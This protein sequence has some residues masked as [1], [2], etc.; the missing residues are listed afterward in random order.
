MAR[1]LLPLLA[2]A[3]SLAVAGA[4]T[5]DSIGKKKQRIDQQLSQVQLQLA[6]S[7]QVEERL[8]HQV[9]TLTTSIHRIELRVGGVSQR[10]SALNRDIALHRERLAKL[11]DL[12]HVQT[13]RYRTL[14][15]QYRLAV[16]RFDERLLR[17]YEEPSPNAVDV[18]LAS[19]SLHDALDAMNYLGAVAAQDKRIATQVRTAS[20][21]AAVAR[22]HTLSVRKTVEA[23]T[24]VIRG[25]AQ[26]VQILQA[27]LLTSRGSLAN[28]RGAKRQQLLA[29][30]KA[31][32]Q[33]VGES[34]SLASASAAL[35]AKLKGEAGGGGTTTTTGGSGGGHKG[36]PHF[37]WP[38][39]GPIT[40]PFGMRWGVLHPGI[41]I[42]VPVG[43]PVH[44]SAAGT[45]VWCGWME[46]YG[47]FVV[48]DHGGGYATAYGHNSSIA[49]S[50]GE[51]VSQGQVIAHS[52][53]TGYCTGPHVHFEIRVDGTPV[54]PLDY[55]G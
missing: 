24:Q 22:R 44:A 48:I 18:L 10:L 15:G 36:A 13:R 31:I 20:R 53:C 17:I 9:G 37:I 30:R 6:A 16:H 12:L 35:A 26:Q 7:K 54:D 39:H 47:N 43:T 21:Q 50:C 27:Q 49:V 41:D 11:D 23:E 33:E 25:R 19:K 46:G 4:A 5:A 42:G 1:R 40:S 38:V 32:S 8:T 34:Q 55:L 2:L 52:G 14:R 51:K 28:L 3:L 45:V 29:T